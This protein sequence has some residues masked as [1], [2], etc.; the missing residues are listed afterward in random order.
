MKVTIP[1]LKL[2]QA[3][4][5]AAL[6]L[7]QELSGTTVIRSSTLPS[8]KMDLQTAANLSR[9]DALKAL[10]E[11]LREKGIFLQPR[12]QKFTFA[13]ELSKVSR[14][15][16]IK[17]APAPPK[18]PVLPN[19]T[20]EV[21]PP[22]LI[23]F[24]EADYNQVLDIYQEL[25]GRT[26]LNSP[27]VPRAKISL[28]T[29]TEVSREEAV[30]MLEAVL[31]LAGISV[32]QEGRQLAFALPGN[33]YATAPK[34]PASPDEERLKKKPFGPVE[35][36][37]LKGSAEGGLPG[38][39]PPPTPPGPLPVGMIFP[40]SSRD[41]LKLYAEIVERE[42][43]FEPAPPAGT[44][45]FRPKGAMHAVEAAYALEALAT[46]NKMQFVPVGDKQVKLVRINPAPPTQGQTKP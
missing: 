16:G 19:A 2:Q 37:Q 27:E 15:A 35:K 4:A 46:M 23:L 28:R 33:R 31:Y 39:V 3:E 24:N 8:S 41:L 44:F 40:A 42:P 9:V 25:S 1:A 38:T 36:L 6:D 5:K 30:W 34:V 17:D 21:F 20:A 18:E 26:V 12:A 14:V 13:T 7:Y 11:A 43:L 22:G 32:V 45:N 29:Q 10:T